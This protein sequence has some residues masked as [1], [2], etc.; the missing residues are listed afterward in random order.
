MLSDLQHVR[1]SANKKKDSVISERARKIAQK[2]FEFSDS[3]VDDF[4]NDTY[5]VIFIIYYNNYYII[6]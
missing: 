4:M 6:L 2:A 3:E 5:Q 1:Q